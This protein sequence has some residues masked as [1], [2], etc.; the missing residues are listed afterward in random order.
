MRP[1]LTRLRQLTRGGLAAAVSLSFVLTMFSPVSPAEAACNPDQICGSIPVTGSNQTSADPTTPGGG[2][3]CGTSSSS[4]PWVI[5]GFASFT[6]YTSTTPL[7]RTRGLPSPLPTEPLSSVNPNTGIT[8]YFYNGYGGQCAMAYKTYVDPIDGQTYYSYA[9]GVSWIDY[10]YW[11]SQDYTTTSLGSYTVTSAMITA[12]GLT[13]VLV[14]KMWIGLTS[15]IYY[16]ADTIVHTAGTYT[17][18]VTT[19]TTKRWYVDRIVSYG[20]CSF[21]A[22]PVYTVTKSCPTYMGP[23]SMNGPYGNTA[24]L[25]KWPVIMANGQVDPATLPRTYTLPRLY[26]PIGTALKDTP[27]IFVKSNSTA[28]SLVQNC[29][30]LI[31]NVTVDQTKCLDSSGNPMTGLSNCKFTPGNYEKVA[32]GKAVTCQYVVN[33]YVGRTAFLSCGSQV[34]CND[35]P[36]CPYDEWAYF[37]CGSGSG[38]GFNDSYDFTNC[39]VPPPSMPQCN[40]SGPTMTLVSTNQ[41]I[42]NGSQVTANGKPIK[43]AWTAT[44]SNLSGRTLENK[45]QQYILAKGS[46][47]VVGA[48]PYTSVALNGANQPFTGTLSAAD[49]SNSLITYMGSTVGVN[50][51]DNPLYVRIYKGGITN[52]GG[53]TSV[54]AGEVLNPV[55]SI[56]TGR[57]MPFG[58]YSVLRSTFKMTTGTTFGSVTLNVPLICKSP[59]A[60][61]YP[62]MGRVSN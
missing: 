1:L 13:G 33:T 40:W 22:S 20:S 14:P 12:A 26:S 2:T 25:G 52:T 28:L 59:M 19:T 53:V 41:S 55:L 57:V 56:P 44:I 54:G 51:W 58:V 34:N 50:S 38:N 45:M 16:G 61:V 7:T 46:K 32:S 29:K 42:A 39:N 60:Y 9:N 31:Y 27:G 35:A 47:P 23:G 3:S 8:S 6:P 37:E 18:V 62:M 5:C 21:P 43:I 49:T 36:N 30:Q 17:V 15:G 10:R 11:T 4:N 24:T 48:P